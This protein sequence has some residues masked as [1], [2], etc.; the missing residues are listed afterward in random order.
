MDFN[1]FDTVAAANKGQ[2][3]HLKS[4][5]DGELLYSSTPDP[6]TG[7]LV[8]DMTKPCRVHVSGAEGKVAQAMVAEERARLL[9]GEKADSSDP[10]GQAR[11][12]SEAAQLINDMENIEKDG[13][14][15]KAP[16]DVLWL[17]GLSKV[18]GT[19]GVF[20]SFQE[21]VRTFSLQRMHNLGNVK[22]S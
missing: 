22:S 3:L 15:A 2:W 12:V 17:L 6:K 20:P 13:V 14:P 9:S 1:V 10:T 19:K 21:Q 7:E 11:V 8:Q 16:D 5:L 18:L 4:P